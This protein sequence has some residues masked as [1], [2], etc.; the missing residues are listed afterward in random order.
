MNII[1]EE[2]ISARI[3]GVSVIIARKSKK[4]KP[5]AKKTKPKTKPKKKPVSK[6]PVEETEET[7]DINEYS[8]MINVSF[9]ADIE[10]K[11]GRDELV[12]L[13][14]TGLQS[15]VEETLGR[16]RRS[17]GIRIIDRS[18][19]VVKVDCALSNIWD[20]DQDQED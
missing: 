14:Q 1:N 11:I 20:H 7:F 12:N 6:L 2:L 17:H 16:I 13:L 5:A 15:A 8:C 19:T 4:K 9:N 10:G 18:A 3:A